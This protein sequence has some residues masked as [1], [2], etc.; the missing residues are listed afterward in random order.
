MA[1]IGPSD[2]DL[3]ELHDAAATAELVVYEELGL[4]E[5]G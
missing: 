4:C 3:V 2:L 5:A 1:G